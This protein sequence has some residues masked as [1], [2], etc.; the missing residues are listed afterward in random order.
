MISVD[1]A[2]AFKKKM[3]ELNLPL[4]N[5]VKHRRA[6]SQAERVETTI[7]EPPRNSVVSIDEQQSILFVIKG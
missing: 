3:R 2:A 5:K 7:K 1:D 4:F 6:T